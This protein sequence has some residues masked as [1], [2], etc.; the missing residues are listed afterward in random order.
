VLK[1]AGPRPELFFALELAA[2]ENLNLLA[3]LAA[4]GALALDGLYQVKAV[5]DLDWVGVV[6]GSGSG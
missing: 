6:G 4:A 5:R 1:K 3:T 2:V